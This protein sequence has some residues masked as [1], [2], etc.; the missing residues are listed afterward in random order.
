[1][2]TA[3][4]ESVI[5]STVK[6]ISLGALDGGVER[7]HALLDVAHDVLEHDDGVVDDEAERQRQRQQADVV[8]REAEHRHAGERADD[9]QRQRERRE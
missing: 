3:T 1:M 2:N 4:S 8:E 9:R 7:L 5:E 6:P